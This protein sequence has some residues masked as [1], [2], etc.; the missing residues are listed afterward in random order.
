MRSFSFHGNEENSEVLS[1]FFVDNRVRRG[2][3]CDRPIG[4][5]TATRAWYA[6]SPDEAEIKMKESAADSSY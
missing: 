6:L 2:K 4:K 5:G 3:H 1:G